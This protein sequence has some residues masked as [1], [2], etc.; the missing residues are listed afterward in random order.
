MLRIEDL[1]AGYGAFKVLNNITLGAKEGETVAVIGPN[2][3]GK[4]T[5]VS[6]IMGLIRPSSGTVRFLDEDITLLKPHEIVEKGIT[7]VPERRRLFSSFSVSENLDMGAFL[8]K[9]R[10]E[11]RKRLELVFENFPVLKDR[12]NQTG[13]TLSGGEQQMLAVARGLM[14]NPKLL[15]LDEPSVGLAPIAIETLY[16]TLSSFPEQGITLLLIEQNVNAALSIA[17]RVYVMSAGKI[18]AEDTVEKIVNNKEIVER[19]L[20]IT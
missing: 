9:N 8:L 4:T 13:G 5:L 15:I 20:T 16:K 17:D 2:G 6:T 18:V 3:A 12:L 14:G 10:E 19:Y 11:K 7:L 1:D